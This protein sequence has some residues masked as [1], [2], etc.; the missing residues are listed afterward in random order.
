MLKIRNYYINYKDIKY[1]KIIE[2][3][4]SNDLT[5]YLK[6]GTELYIVDVSEDDL[7]KL[8]KVEE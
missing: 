1:V 5:V 6:D 4:R 7:L 8:E 2:F 3:K